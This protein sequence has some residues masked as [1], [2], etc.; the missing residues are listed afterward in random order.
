MTSP[1]PGVASLRKPK[2]LR[3][4]SRLAIFAPASPANGSRVA[5][6]IEELRRLGYVVDAPVKA[7]SEG[8]FAASVAERGAEFL[9]KLRDQ[10]VDGLVAL[11]GGYGS[12]YLLDQGLLDGLS[13]AKSIIGFSDLTSLQIF[14]WQKY[15][16]V[17][18]YGPMV[19]AGFDGAT[20]ATGGYDG[21]SFRRAVSQIDGG[22]EIPLRGESLVRGS[23]EGPILG[24]AMT[25]IEATLGTPWELDT[26]GAILVLEDRGMKP[27]QV[28]RVLMHLTQAGKLREVRGVILGD[29]PECEPPVS[30]SP[31][32]REV[33]ARILGPTG[34][35]VIYGAPAGHTRRPILTLPLGV[36]GRL[37]A[38]GE[39]VLEIL[40]PAVVA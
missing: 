23:A 20:G 33:C 2:A 40:E 39:G 38:E 3:P 19:S 4:D 6:G 5:A 7:A 36:R 12:N 25:L 21:E 26:R 14:L 10:S 30:G 15:R 37:R 8:Y 16:W 27:Y 24:G 13:E 29:F 11:R 9:N 31:T 1:E 28:D 34:V 32:V 17:T 35:P 18:F 22:W